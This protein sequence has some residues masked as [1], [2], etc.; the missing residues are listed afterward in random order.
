LLTDKDD[1]VCMAAIR[2]LGQIIPRLSRGDRLASVLEIERR[3]NCSEEKTS[4][5]ITAMRAIDQ[6]MDSLPVRDRLGRVMAIEACLISEEESLRANA[7]DYVVRITVDLSRGFRLDRARA[8]MGCFKH[9]DDYMRM[10][11]VAALTDII[12]LLP[13]EERL[14]P[15]LEIEWLLGDLHIDVHRTAAFSLGKILPELRNQD[16]VFLKQKVRSRLEDRKIRLRTRDVVVDALVK[17]AAHD[18][19]RERLELAL[20]LESQSF[21]SPLMHVALEELKGHLWKGPFRELPPVIESWLE[22]PESGRCRVA[23]LYMRDIHSRWKEPRDVSQ[24][25]SWR[26]QLNERG[27]PSEKREAL[28]HLAYSY[29]PTLSLEAVRRL[30]LQGKTW[31]GERNP[32]EGVGDRVVRFAKQLLEVERSC[33]K[34]VL[35]EN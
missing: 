32:S 22:S 31:L 5:R 9:E 25:R 21:V 24:L 11:A 1:L 2:A 10:V 16:A 30:I 27:R 3:L 20:T 17:M 7:V 29:S 14:M 34:P 12:P 13:S 4:V 35:L 23:L 33:R 28:I 18:S 15:T 26:N 6:V 19:Q 8:I